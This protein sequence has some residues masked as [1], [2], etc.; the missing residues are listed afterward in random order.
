MT[1][2]LGELYDYA[3]VCTVLCVH[4]GVRPEVR[5]RLKQLTQQKESR[6]GGNDV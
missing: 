2:S 5:N 3:Y 4:L 1:R 6:G